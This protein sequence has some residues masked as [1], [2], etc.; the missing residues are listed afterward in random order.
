[1]KRVALAALL[2]LALQAVP[3]SAALPVDTNPLGTLKVLPGNAV[4]KSEVPAGAVRMVVVFDRSLA[5][6]SGVPGQGAP[7]NAILATGDFGARF[8]GGFQAPMAPAPA[9]MI[10]HHARLDDVKKAADGAGFP[11]FPADVSNAVGGVAGDVRDAACPAAGAPLLW[12]YSTLSSSNTPARAVDGPCTVVV[13]SL[14]NAAGTWDNVIR[15]YVPGFWVDF[16][17]PA[18]VA[19]GQGA[20]KYAAAYDNNNSPGGNFWDTAD[21]A[22]IGTWTGSI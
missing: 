13:S 4:E 9:Q 15:T 8:T 17:S 3:A 1:M 22:G 16:R 18:G 7:T 5:L 2:L 12:A 6:G 19:G 11:G 21:A 20:F 14:Q 10:D